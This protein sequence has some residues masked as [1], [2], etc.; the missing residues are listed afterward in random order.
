M[1][2]SNGCRRGFLHWIG[3]GDDRG[4]LAINCC[5]KRCLAFIAKATCI[6]GKNSHVKAKLCHITIGTDRNFMTGNTGFQA[7][8]RDRFKG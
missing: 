4:K 3:N 8:A 6:I 2:R 5:I 1:H 7:K